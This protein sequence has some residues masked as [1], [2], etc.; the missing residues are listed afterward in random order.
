MEVLPFQLCLEEELRSLF[1]F[2]KPTTYSIR[3]EASLLFFCSLCQLNPFF[4][5]HIRVLTSHAPP[6]RVDGNL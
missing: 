2:K 3:V 4:L 1:S 5:E 6:Q